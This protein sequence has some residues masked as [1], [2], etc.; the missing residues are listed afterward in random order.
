M[1]PNLTPLTQEQKQLVEQYFRYAAASGMN[2][3]RQ[4]GLGSFDADE[5]VAE[6]LIRLVYAARA[7]H[8]EGGVPFK[9]YLAVTF[10][11]SWRQFH[12]IVSGAKHQGK[13]GF[14]SPVMV[15]FQA[16]CSESHYDNEIPFEEVYWDETDDLPDEIVDKKMM[17][18]RLRLCLTKLPPM[19]IFV[20]EKHVLEG[21][22]LGDIGN[23]LGVSRQNVHQIY[24]AA[25][26]EM[27]RMLQG[28]SALKHGRLGKKT[29]NVDL[30]EVRV[31]RTNRG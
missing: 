31:Q 1:Q 2:K 21:H 16:D 3:A 9:N 8:H 29:R 13:G 25:C 30:D 11:S 28:K 18:E 6:Y 23:A 17:I 5:L 27:L 10:K 22:T 15:S 20:L 24:K 14:F 26:Q 4:L 7:Y 19:W 12:V